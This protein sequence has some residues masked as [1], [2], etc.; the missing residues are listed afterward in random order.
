VL[1]ATTTVAFRA[2]F[3][4]HVHYVWG[5][6]RLFGVR[7]ADLEDLSHEVFLTVHRLLPRFDTSRPVR[8]WLFSIAHHAALGYRRRVH[9]HR[10]VF[11]DDH[12]AADDAPAADELM[13]RKEAMSLVHQALAH[14]EVERR[15]V[16]MLIDMDGC[17]A[18]EAADAL[19]IPLNTVYSRLRRARAEFSEALER[20]RKKRGPRER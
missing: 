17:S 3:E 10:E 20:L 8:P 11:D 4:E 5:T 1:A 18:P 14:L 12:D 6:L 16:L 2:L 9:H 7:P 15:A 13:V 19:S